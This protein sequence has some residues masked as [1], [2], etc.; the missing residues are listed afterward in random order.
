LSP[1]SE[2]KVGR[3][4]PKAEASWL[5]GLLS[6]GPQP[7]NTIIEAANRLNYSES[8]LRRAAKDLIASFKVDKT[9]YWRLRTPA[10]DAEQSIN[11][12]E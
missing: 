3:A 9:G 12:A 8:T 5:I 10:D 4:K 6:D 7:I 1:A 2:E 11:D